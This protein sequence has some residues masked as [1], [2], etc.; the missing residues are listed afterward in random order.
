MLVTEIMSRPVVTA[1]PTETVAAAASRMGE[2]GVGSVVVTEGERAV[3]ILTERDLVRVASAG[4]EASTEAV[5]TWM[6]PE[7]DSV[8]SRHR[9]RG[10]VRQ[11]GGARVPPHPRRRRRAPRRPG[12]DARPHA[13][14]EIQPADDLAHEL[15][16]GLEGVIVAETSSA[17]CAGSRASTTTASTTRSSWPRSARSKT[18]GTS[19]SKARL[20]TLG[21]RERVPAR[22]APLREIPRRVKAVLPDLA[23]RRRALRPLDLLRTTV[24]LM[25]AALGFRPSL[26]LER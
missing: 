16:R 11:P 21:E 25:G 14:R 17:T 10:C 19:C 9:G 18:S 5:A 26:D 7:P 24:S 2:Q 8:G 22:V 6:T 4:V 20:P 13:S 3:G 15:P 23:G 12:L 1:T